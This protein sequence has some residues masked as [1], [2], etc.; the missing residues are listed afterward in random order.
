VIKMAQIQQVRG[1][2]TSIRTDIFKQMT[3]IRYH[4]TDVVT[5]DNLKIILNTGG[6]FTNTTK[7]RMNQAANQ[8]NL[9]F[10]VFQKNGYWYVQLDNGVVLDYKDGMEFDR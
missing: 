5:F 6:W 3:Y 4:N 7:T 1:V 9:G 2:A 10:K 8:F